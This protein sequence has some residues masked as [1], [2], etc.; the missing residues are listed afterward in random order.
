MVT[1]KG[2]N[3]VI[4]SREYA[5]QSSLYWLTYTLEGRKLISEHPELVSKITRDAQDKELL[6][7]E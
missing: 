6:Y 2:L 5:G 7:L 4:I 1:Q 3:Q